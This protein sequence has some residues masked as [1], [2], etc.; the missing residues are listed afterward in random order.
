MTLT[1]SKPDDR[2]TLSFLPSPIKSSANIF[3]LGTVSLPGFFASGFATLVKGNRPIL[4]PDTTLTYLDV[5][6]V[7][8]VYVSW[9]RT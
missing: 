5:P 8:V 3:N 2:F 7:Y 4:E 9:F 1:G 6:L